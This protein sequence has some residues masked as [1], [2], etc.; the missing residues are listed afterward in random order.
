VSSADTV[1]V[2]AGSG[3]YYA[4][5]AVDDVARGFENEYRLAL[6][7]PAYNLWPVPIP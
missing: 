6:A 3:R 2:P 4:I 5:L 1:E 7:E